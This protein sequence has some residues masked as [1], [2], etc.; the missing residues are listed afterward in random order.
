MLSF[1][2]CILSRCEYLAAAEFIPDHRG[3][4][5]MNEYSFFN[6]FFY[7]FPQNRSLK[8]IQVDIG[9]SLLSW[10]CNQCNMI[11]QRTIKENYA[12]TQ[13]PLCALI[14]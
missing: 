3:Y 13:F 2:L 1:A 10:S 4:M 9:Q 5:D 6:S 7:I 8:F 12:V 14:D 11:D